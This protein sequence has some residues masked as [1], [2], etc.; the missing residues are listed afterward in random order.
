MSKSGSRWDLVPL[1]ASS[2]KGGERGVL[3]VS[4]LD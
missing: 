4:G 3:K 1:P 2:I